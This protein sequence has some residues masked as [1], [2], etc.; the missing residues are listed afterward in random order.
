MNTKLPNPSYYRKYRS[1]AQIYLPACL[2]GCL[3][4]DSARALYIVTDPS[5]DQTHH[6]TVTMETARAR[7]SSPKHN[8][9]LA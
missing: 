9:P 4:I 8:A 5:V 2:N 7:S 3:R 1:D 6:V